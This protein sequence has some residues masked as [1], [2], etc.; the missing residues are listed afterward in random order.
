MSNYLSV[1]PGLTVFLMKQVSTRP[2]HFAA[3]TL[4]NIHEIF[5]GNRQFDASGSDPVFS[6]FKE[7]DCFST[8][9]EKAQQIKDKYKQKVKWMPGW[10]KSLNGVKEEETK[11][12][13]L[14]ETIQ[15]LYDQK[16]AIQVLAKKNFL[17]PG[18]LGHICSFLPIQDLKSF[19]QASSVI[20]ETSDLSI[21][22]RAQEEYGY[23]KNDVEGAKLYLDRLFKMLDKPA[24]KESLSNRYYVWQN[25]KLD[26]AATLKK[27][28]GISLRDFE[29]SVSYDTRPCVHSDTYDGMYVDFAQFLTFWVAKRTIKAK[30]PL[31]KFDWATLFFRPRNMSTAFLK[32]QLNRIKLLLLLGA[33]PNTRFD[34]WLPNHMDPYANDTSACTLLHA[35]ME[36]HIIFEQEALEILNLLLEDTT[37]NVNDPAGEAD[38]SPLLLAAISG[39]LLFAQKL[40]EKGAHINQTYLHGYQLSPFQ[41]AVIQGHTQMAHYFIAQGANTTGKS[42]AFNSA[43]FRFNASVTR[44]LWEKRGKKLPARWISHTPLFFLWLLFQRS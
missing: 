9:N 38:S 2:K 1:S 34:S 39:N 28:R 16:Y 27:L 10:L 24:I 43:R 6:C 3:S 18:V 7:E 35:I 14:A 8:L 32:I 23:E 41:M 31:K 20:K 17:Y 26:H 29:A 22:K 40:V 44:S 42:S 4:C 13:Q 21:L 12:I 11:I 36:P 25:E 19:A 33:D 37:V 5:T 15:N 30:K